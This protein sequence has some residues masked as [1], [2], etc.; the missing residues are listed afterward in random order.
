MN[1]TRKGLLAIVLSLYR[2]TGLLTG[3]YSKALA[4]IEQAPHGEVGAGD[5]RDAEKAL[6][7]KSA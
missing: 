7:T 3:I 1:P 2:L 6:L 5:A 4:G